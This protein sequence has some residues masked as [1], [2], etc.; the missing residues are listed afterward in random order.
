MDFHWSGWFGIVL[1]LFDRF[2]LLPVVILRAHIAQ[3]RSRGRHSKC[4]PFLPSVLPSL[5]ENFQ[6]VSGVGL[7]QLGRLTVDF[8]PWSKVDSA[9]R[10][11]GLHNQ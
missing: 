7:L 11:G 1:K 8:R 10:T 9:L 2:E 6:S 3:Q 5:R 4:P